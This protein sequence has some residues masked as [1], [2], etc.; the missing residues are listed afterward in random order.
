MAS[1]DPEVSVGY[2]SEE[3]NDRISCLAM[4]FGLERLE[5][6]GVAIG[7]GLTVLEVSGTMSDAR[8]TVWDGE[9][10]GRR[11]ALPELPGTE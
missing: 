5:L 2:V 1:Q 7:I 8:C 6:I 9:T 11:I 4:Q 3:T 10:Q